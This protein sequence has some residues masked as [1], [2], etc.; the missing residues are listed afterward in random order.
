MG[1]AI[2][3]LAPKPNPLE[4]SAPFVPVDGAPNNGAGAAG[5]G[6]VAPGVGVLA[7][8]M[9]FFS[10]FGVD[11]AEGPNVKGDFEGV[12]ASGSGALV[13][14]PKAKGDVGVAAVVGALPKRGLGASIVGAFV[15]VAD[16]GALVGPNVNGFDAS[17]T[18]GVVAVDGRDPNPVKSGAGAE[19]EE[20]NNED[21]AVEGGL[22][23][24]LGSIFF[25]PPAGAP[26][27]K[28]DAEAAVAAGASEGFAGTPNENGAGAEVVAGA[29]VSVAGLGGTPKENGV[30]AAA[31]AGAASLGAPPNRDDAAGMGALEPKIDTG[32]ASFAGSGAFGVR[33]PN[34]E[35]G[36]AE[37]G[38]AELVDAGA[39]NNEGASGGTAGFAVSVLL[40]GG[41][42]KNEGVTLGASSACLMTGGTPKEN[43]PAAG[44]AAAAVVAGGVDDEGV[45][46]N[47]RLALGLLKMAALAKKFGTPAGF[48]LS[49]S[50]AGSGAGCFSFSF[51]A[52]AGLGGMRAMEGRVGKAGAAGA[53]TAAGAANVAG[54]GA[55]GAGAGAGVEKSDGNGAAGVGVVFAVREKGRD[56][57]GGSLALAVSC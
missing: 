14:A 27:E 20:G 42:P 9:N 38:G 30:V 50:F 28:G 48:S 34:N 25:S 23:V 55:D 36:G 46:V 41:A 53:G 8:N 1:L 17:A 5:V 18:E 22:G 40:A 37:L 57:I 3:V 31:G 29:T 4:T 51:S 2:G 10:G 33:P 26:K 12:G 43:P 56:A 49:C 47:G 15:A 32:A 11:G 54:A 44:A 52:D 24:S 35:S 13:D 39:P 21:G 16:D 7:P 19:L 45:N 6:V